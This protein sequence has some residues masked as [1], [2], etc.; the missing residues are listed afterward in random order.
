[1]MQSV[2]VIPA[3]KGAQVVLKKAKAPASAVA[4]GVKKTTIT[5]NARAASAAVSNIVKHYR[6]DLKKVNKKRYLL[7]A[8]AARI[9]RIIQGQLP[10]KAQKPGAFRTRAKKN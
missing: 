1:M 5:K 6:P 10:V 3:A 8:A 4:K 2:A 7:Q 9:A